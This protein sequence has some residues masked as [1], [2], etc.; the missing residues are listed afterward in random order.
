MVSMAQPNLLEIFIRVQFMRLYPLRGDKETLDFP[1]NGNWFLASFVHFCS[2]H[3]QKVLLICTK[4]FLN[5]F[6]NASYGT[7]M[8]PLWRPYGY[9]LAL[10]MPLVYIKNYNF[11]LSNKYYFHLRWVV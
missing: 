7:L 11:A 1:G 4:V 8:V 3:A 10:A 5:P 6:L 9:R 2:K